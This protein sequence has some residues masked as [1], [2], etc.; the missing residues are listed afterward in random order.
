MKKNNENKK[1]KNVSS[2][3]LPTT[4]D[5][6]D[7]RS[8][9][10]NPKAGVV[11][12]KGTDGATTFENSDL[13]VSQLSA[14]LVKSTLAGTE[15]VVPS[16]ASTGDANNI[17][18]SVTDSFT[19]IKSRI[20]SDESSLAINGIV[21]SYTG[22]LNNLIRTGCYVVPESGPPVVNCP[23]DVSDPTTDVI[24]VVSDETSIAFSTQLYFHRKTAEFYIRTKEYG[25]GA[26]IPWQKM[27]T[28]GWVNNLI[29]NLQTQVNKISYSR[30]SVVSYSMTLSEWSEVVTSNSFPSSYTF[31]LRTAIFNSSFSIG[32]LI[33]VDKSLLNIHVRQDLFGRIN[34]IGL[35]AVSSTNNTTPPYFSVEN[36][37]VYL[38]IST[39]PTTVKNYPTATIPNVYLSIEY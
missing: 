29:G 25:G 14:D 17:L 9:L 13:I 5:V 8:K 21:N 34:T 30:K 36:T 32:C 7:S 11:Y 4:K 37:N 33:P 1:T 26:I 28:Q 3:E 16:T 6:N 20:L 31:Q 23:A 15:G 24:F 19:A 35:A 27:A 2:E 12:T 18:R 39:S 10:I 22:D 38:D